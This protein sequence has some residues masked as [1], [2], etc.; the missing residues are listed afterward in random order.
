M[1]TIN[2]INVDDYF[3]REDGLVWSTY[4]NMFLKPTMN[5]DYYCVGFK[6]KTKRI[7][8]LVAKCFLPNPS[9]LPNV[10]HNDGN[11]LNNNV[12]NLRWGTQ[13]ENMDDRAKHGNDPHGSKCARAKLIE[14][15]VL[16]MRAKSRSGNSNAELGREYNLARS[17]VGRIINRKTWKHI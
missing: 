12:S 10:L 4:R 3:I 2:A 6:G 15:E 8:H 9:N 13:Q 1:T 5:G 17:T 7:H 11:P 14:S 16:E